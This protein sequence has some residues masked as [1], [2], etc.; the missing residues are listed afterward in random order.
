L[1]VTLNSIKEVII[2][3]HNK[4]TVQNITKSEAIDDQPIL[5]WCNGVLFNITIPNTDESFIKQTEGIEYIDTLTWAFSDK[6]DKS[7]WNGYSVEVQDVTGHSLYEP[8][9]LSLKE[10]GVC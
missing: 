3:H 4:T 2:F 6:I 8:L 5:F 1:K 7:T 10:Q 9:T